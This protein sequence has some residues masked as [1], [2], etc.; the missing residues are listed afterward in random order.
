MVLECEMAYIVL[1]EDNQDVA[2]VV[3]DAR[4]WVAMI[5]MMWRLASA[6]WA[7]PASVAALMV[8]LNIAFSIGGW[9]GLPSAMRLEMVTMLPAILI[10]PAKELIS[11]AELASDSR[12]R[13]ARQMLNFRH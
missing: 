4:C 8:V 6:A 3:G 11:D 7:L 9:A 10:I 2:E 13:S 5:K 1:V 12:N